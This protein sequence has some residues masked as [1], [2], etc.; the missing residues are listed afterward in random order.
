[1]ATPPNIS[2]GFETSPS[3]NHAV[4]FNYVWDEN[5][6]YWTP[7]KDSSL[8]FDAIVSN[9]SAFIHKFGSNPDVV[10]TVSTTS[11]ETVWDGSSAYT[12]PSDS[13]E[14][15]QIKSSQGA[16][17]QQFVVQGLDANFELQTWTGN[18]NGTTDVDID[19]TWTRVFRA[20]NNG[21]TSIAGNIN[22]HADGD[23]ST[24]YAQALAG[25]DQTLM[26]VYTVPAN[27]TGYLCEY[28][29]SAHNAGSSSEIGYTVQIKTRNYGK[30]FRVQEVASVTT[31]NS[32]EQ[33][34]PFPLPLAPK[35]DII[36]NVVS[37]NG[38]NGAVNADFDIA[39]LQ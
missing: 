30:V 31:S 24:S 28:H 5:N 37:A 13:G 32:F 9:A 15:I 23:P 20:Y 1:M 35:T 2:N 16:D 25:N 12:F 21:S 19:G 3:R 27:Y 4:N 36:I 18:L 33:T 22:I 34:Y 26:S 6:S 17:T 39:L 8:S 10:N 29:L 7:Q 11:P 14:S 38:N